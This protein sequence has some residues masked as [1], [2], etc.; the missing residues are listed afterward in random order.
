MSGQVSFLPARLPFD[1]HGVLA[2]L[3]ARAVP[4]LEQVDASSYRRAIR[5]DGG[6]IVLS[7]SVADSGVHIAVPGGGDRAGRVPVR[8]VAD[9]FDLEADPAVIGHVLGADGALAV[10]VGANPGLR[11]PGTVDPAETAIRTVLGQQVSVSAARKLNERLVAAYGDRI[12]APVGAVTHAFPTMETLAESDLAAVG[13]PGARRA[14]V[15]ALA[16]AIARGTLRLEPVDDPAT[17]FR[18]LIAIRGVGE[19][20]AAYIALR[21]LGHKDAFPAADAGIRRGARSLGL[22]VEAGA[23]ISRAESWRPWRAYAAHHLWSAV[24]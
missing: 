23:L 2:W 15:R 4:G 5:V 10:S 9:L 8:G 12:S 24:G 19:W 17:T 18:R 1:G 13:M 20:T 21:A 11:A 22:D 16:T 14:T 6:P 3:A 7:L